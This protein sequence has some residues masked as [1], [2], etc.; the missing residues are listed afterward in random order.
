MAGPFKHK[1][2]NFDEQ[3]TSKPSIRQGTKPIMGEYAEQTLP[4]EQPHSQLALDM[5]QTKLSETVPW[6]L[7]HSGSDLFEY[8]PLTS[9]VP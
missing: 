1:G 6:D 2:G 7:A 4:M 3:S 5:L 9:E 8:V